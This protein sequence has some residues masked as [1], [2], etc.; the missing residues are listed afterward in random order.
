METVVNNLLVTNHLDNLPSIHCRVLLT[1]PLESVAV[2]NT[3]LLSR[4]L[5]DVL[6]DEPSLAAMLAHEL[7]HIVLQ[8]TLNITSTKYGFQDRLLMPDEDL[9]SRL[10]FRPD[11]H[12]EAAADQKAVEILKNSPYKDQLAKAGLFLRAMSDAAPHT[13]QLF[14]SHFGSRLVQGNQVRRVGELMGGAPELQKNRVDQ[15]SALPLGA[16]VKIDPWSDRAQLVK[17]NS[18]ALLSARE[19]MP[20]E[21]TPLFPYLTRY[22]E[23]QE[24]STDPTREQ[25]TAQ[26]QGGV[27]PADPR[28]QP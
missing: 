26:Q 19:K 5:I 7:G 6:P 23:A 17:S 20:F 4:G 2:G 15:I 8:H 3:I 24:Q 21:A 18:V 28:P 9:M 1:S 27:R 14:G 11:E 10:N 13:P 25:N 16:R 12:D 22:G